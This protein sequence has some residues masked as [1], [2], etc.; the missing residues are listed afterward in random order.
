MFRLL[1]EPKILVT[2][3]KGMIGQILTAAFSNDFDVYE[4]DIKEGSG[5]KYF[6]TDIS[7]YEELESVFRKIGRIDCVVHLAADSR[8]NAE[9]DSVLR[10]NIVGTKTLYECVR[11]HG[12]R[13]VV[14][15]SSNR[16]TGSY[17]PGQSIATHDPVR[18]D[19]DYGSSK[20]FGEIIARQYFDLYGI[21]SICLRIGWV[22]RDD[23]P[24][25]DDRWTTMWL[26]HRDLVE[27]IRRS[28]GADVDFGIYYGVSNNEGSPFNI[29][30]AMKELGYR[31]K[32]NASTKVARR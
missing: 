18:P 13:K 14:F 17:G 5:K 26:S 29:F 21:K 19:G 25:V 10:N 16:V 32:D 11:R 7:D 1:K 22:P 30:N 23:D 20:A 27:L 9:W 28:I 31:P 24:A 4:L 8:M 3:S 15:A 6:R 2:G 12:I